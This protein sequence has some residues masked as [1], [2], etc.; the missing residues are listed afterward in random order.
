MPRHSSTPSCMTRAKIT[1]RAILGL[2]SRERGH[3]V[4][5]EMLEQALLDYRRNQ[6]SWDELIHE[7]ERHGLAPLLYKHLQ[8]VE[9]NLPKDQQRMLR[10][11]HQR[12]RF[13][14]LVR[15]RAVE[16][17]LQRCRQEQIVSMPVKGIALANIV[18]E[19]AEYRPMRDIDLLVAKEDLQRSEQLLIEL[20]YRRRKSHHIPDDYYHLPPLVKTIDGLPV[21]IELHHDLL[22]LEESYP[23]WP[24]EK[25]LSASLPLTI[26]A[27]QTVT[28]NLEDGL[29][30]LYLHGFRAPLSYEEFRFIHLADIVTLVEKYFHKI[31]WDRAAEQF[32]NLL[33]I[34]SRL[35]FVTPWRSEIISSLDLDVKT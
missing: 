20:G 2:C 14:A 35:H 9:F 6:Q 11:L 3:P 10:S 19:K 26:G 25:S 5:H 18:Y 16:T 30:Y 22:P 21:A 1:G 34:L 27:S 4:M 13:S 8:E 15:N 31:D 17:I 24:L 7:A 33:P 28:L 23:R 12:N 29:Y 32:S